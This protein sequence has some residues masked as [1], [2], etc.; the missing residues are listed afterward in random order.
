MKTTC[1]FFGYWILAITLTHQ[2][3]VW[4]QGTA[5]IYQ[6]RLND[7]PGLASGTYDLI[8]TVYDAVTGGNISGGPLTRANT[9]V[10]NGL[11]TVTLDF[12]VGVFSGPARW[13][14][15][16]VRTNGAA[17]F[18]TLSPRQ[19]LA[20]TPYSITAGTISGPLPTAQLSG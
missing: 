1:K 7:G 18:F 9:A 11:F 10:S 13:L 12:G 5:F 3:A 19:A 20:A 17:F 8:F 14:E 16:G 15:I 6:G 4:A 2:P